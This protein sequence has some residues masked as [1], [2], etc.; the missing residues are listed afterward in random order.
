MKQAW[1]QKFGGEG[2][3][4]LPMVEERALEMP[5]LMVFDFLGEEVVSCQWVAV[6]LSL[7][8]T[9]SVFPHW[10]QFSSSLLLKEQSP[11]SPPN[12]EALAYFLAGLERRLLVVLGQPLVEVWEQKFV[13]IRGQMCMMNLGSL[14]KY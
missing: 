5:E 8:P 1:A 2:A 10:P 14:N 11:M 6:D 7:M 9:T 13:M 4:A 3:L 12:S